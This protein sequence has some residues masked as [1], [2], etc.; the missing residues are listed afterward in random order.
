MNI[1]FLHG[2]KPSKIYRSEL[3]EQ[4][5]ADKLLCYFKD[6]KWQFFPNILS[7]C[8]YCIALTF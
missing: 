7:D 1:F 5:M 4:C 6:S 3:M 2:I 8:I